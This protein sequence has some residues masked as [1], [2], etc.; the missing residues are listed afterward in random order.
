MQDE[1]EPIPVE[2]GGSEPAS[3]LPTRQLVWPSERRT[4]RSLIV[5]IGL[6]IITAFSTLAAGAQF[7]AAYAANRSPGFESFF[8]DYFRPFVE[9]GLFVSGIPFA[10]TLLGILLAHE[11][12]H[13]FA[14]RHYHISATYP[15]FIP[16]PTLIG[17]LGAF[18][19]IRS[20]IFNRRALFDMALAGPLVGFLIA[21]PALAS[22]VLF[23][24]VITPSDASYSLAFGQPLVE[25][26][27]ELVLR[28]GI[29]HAC[30]LLH[31]VGRAAW[32][33]LFATAL[34]LLPAGQLD[35]GHIL[36]AV[37]ARRHRQVSFAVAL[38]LVPLAV[39]FWAGWLVWAVLLVAIGFRHPPLIDRWEPLD[40]RRRIL[41]GIALAIFIL[42]FMPAPF[43][44]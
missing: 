42:C 2:L 30:L 21:V 19:R 26:L 17:T 5:A 13:F 22:A 6:F 20:P 44:V 10:V 1:P 33:G 28:P 37:A 14:C 7:A 36:Y 11:L 40:R 24:K 4:I 16:A 8:S 43:V 3:W 41:S 12:G 39:K 25:R 18:I 35:G 38:L 23:S 15:Y 27:L 9:P 32:V 29:P 31:P 34:N